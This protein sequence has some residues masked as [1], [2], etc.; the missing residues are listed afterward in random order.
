MNRMLNRS[1]ARE[2]AARGIKSN[3]TTS[4]KIAVTSKKTIVDLS[5]TPTIQAHDQVVTQFAK[6]LSNDNNAK[7]KPAKEGLEK[8]NFL[9]MFDKSLSENNLNSHNVADVYTAYII[10]SWEAVT[11]NDA[12]KYKIG[13]AK[14]RDE[15]REKLNNSAESKFSNAQKQLA[16]ESL[17]YLAVFNYL[18][19][20]ELAKKGD[21]VTLNQTRANIAKMTANIAGIDVSRYVLNDS[22][23]KI[24]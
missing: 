13:I 15:I 11:G 16:S 8:A 14:F 19:T 3:S 7:I 6:V 5:F 18:S 10:F 22:G 2:R 9:G 24:R 1:F 12:T 23:F 17:A 4:S 20:Q 21:A